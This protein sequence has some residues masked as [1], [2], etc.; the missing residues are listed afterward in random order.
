[1]E[2]SWPYQVLM[3]HHILWIFQIHQ[4]TVTDETGTAIFEVREKSLVFT[5]QGLLDLDTVHHYKVTTRL[6]E[7][8]SSCEA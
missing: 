6:M 4:F 1:M 5:L 2:T 7:E 3:R 8:R